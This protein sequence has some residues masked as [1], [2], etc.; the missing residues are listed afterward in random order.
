MPNL[1]DQYIKVVFDKL[2]NVT[3]HR[4]LYVGD[5]LKVLNANSYWVTPH[6]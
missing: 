6:C 1:R 2:E 4:K 3:P 5:D